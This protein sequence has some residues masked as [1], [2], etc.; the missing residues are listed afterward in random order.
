MGYHTGKIISYTTRS[1]ECRRCNAGWLK[2][3]HDCRKNFSG[4]SKA[5]EPDMAVELAVHNELFTK[6]NVFCARL[7]ADD[8]STTI[9]NL[10]RNCKHNVLKLSDKNHACKNFKKALYGLK[11]NK[12]LIE[13]LYNSF[14]V[15]LNHYKGDVA[16]LKV[17]LTAIFLIVLGIIRYVIFTK[18]KKITNTT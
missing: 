18:I 17:A 4:T 16:G 8:D 9:D 1:K 11:L 10:R 5:M 12:D 14:L 7:V 2:K 6:H 13:Y 3:N 15:N